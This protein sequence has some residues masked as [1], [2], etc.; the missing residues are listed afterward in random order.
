MTVTAAVNQSN[1]G[2]KVV[3]RDISWQELAINAWGSEYR[4]PDHNMY[5][6]SN[7]RGFDS[8]DL[9][10]GGVYGVTDVNYLMLED[11]RYPDMASN[12]KILQDSGYGLVLS[13]G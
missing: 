6:F 7:M 12:S 11:S 4:A 5:V 2:N 9:N 13:H 3:S 1:L 10:A 8:T